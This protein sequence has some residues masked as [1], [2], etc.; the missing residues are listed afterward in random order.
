[1][2]LTNQ[3]VTQTILYVKTG[4]D[5]T[6]NV[7]SLSIPLGTYKITW[8]V[9]RLAKMTYKHY[10]AALDNIT[11]TTG[12][13][14]EI[15]LS[16]LE[17]VDNNKIWNCANKAFDECGFVDVSPHPVKWINIMTKGLLLIYFGSILSILKYLAMLLYEGN[18]W[19]LNISI[20]TIMWP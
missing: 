9:T 15:S 20:S 14:L 18:H 8:K 6:W 19:L 1:M 13:C 7:V 3:T 12:D 10:I 4:T 2:Y 5:G 17:I 16:L 11:I